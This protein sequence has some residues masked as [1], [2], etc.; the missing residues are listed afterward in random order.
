MNGVPYMENQKFLSVGESQKLF[1][2]TEL[3]FCECNLY[4][5]TDVHLFVEH[6]GTGNI[7]GNEIENMPRFSK[8]NCIATFC[9]SC[10]STGSKF[11]TR[12]SFF[13]PSVYISSY[14]RNVVMS[15]GHVFLIKNYSWDKVVL[16]LKNKI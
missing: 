11:C 1:F 6:C 4:E 2:C 5:R 14:I 10:Y 8:V 9:R 3:W 16:H 15:T 7:F 13:H 12:D